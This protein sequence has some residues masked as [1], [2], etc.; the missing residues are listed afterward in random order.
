[1]LMPE[2]NYAEKLWDMGNYIT[3]FAVAQVIATSF[4]IGKTELK[5]LAGPLAHWLAFAATVVFTALYV[6]SISWC[7]DEGMNLD[8]VQPYIWHRITQCRI[9]TVLIFTVVLIGALLGH[10]RSEKERRLAEARNRVAS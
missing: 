8:K 1:M 2:L 6:I 7:G 5:L 4:A 3:A 9:I 10:W